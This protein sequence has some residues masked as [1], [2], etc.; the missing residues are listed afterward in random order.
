MVNFRKAEKSALDQPITA[1]GHDGAVTFDGWWIDIERTGRLAKIS[2]KVNGY[3]SKRIPL[4][5]VEQVV[6]KR[7][8]MLING[9]LEF[10][11]SGEPRPHGKTTG[12]AA[13]PNAVLV[14]KQ[15]A[16]RFE[17]LYTALLEALAHIRT[18]N[19]G[20]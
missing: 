5:R 19:P 1:V 9:Y 11:V 12:A 6:W 17:P 10:V 2:A 13:N 14:T 4:D 7:P 18:E 8:S 3:E 20:R 15:Q 16:T